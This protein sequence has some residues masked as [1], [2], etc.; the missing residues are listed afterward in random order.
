MKTIFTGEKDPR[1]AKSVIGETLTDM[2]ETDPDVIYLDADLMSCIGTLKYAKT[3]PDRAIEC[4]VA[5]A[6]MIGVACGL[7][8]AGFK[9]VCHTFGPFAS[10]R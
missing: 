10:R 5:E 3:H 8:S 1:L 6:N 9:P 2:L 4:G 7:A